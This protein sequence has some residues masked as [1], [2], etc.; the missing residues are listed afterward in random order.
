MKDLTGQ[1]FG[2]LTALEPTDKRKGTS[3]VWQCECECGNIC[4]VRSTSLTTG[5]TKSCG[6]LKKEKQALWHK[7]MQESR[8]RHSRES[9]ERK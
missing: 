9:K 6:C 1:K 5:N 3:V 7:K 2:R 8:E 4:E